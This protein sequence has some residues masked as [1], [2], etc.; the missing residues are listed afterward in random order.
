[1]VFPKRR[2]RET[3]CS[4][5]FIAKRREQ[6]GSSLV[7][8]SFCLVSIIAKNPGAAESHT[9]RNPFVTNERHV[10]MVACTV[11]AVPKD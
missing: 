9:Q 8:C 7:F 10:G 4:F 11:D 2:N 1:M 3:C 5:R 6:E